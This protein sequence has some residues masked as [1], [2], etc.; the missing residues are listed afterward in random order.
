M[1]P[2]LFA[3]LAVR[4]VISH[5]MVGALSVGLIASIAGHFILETGRREI[6]NIYEDTAF[7]IGHDRE[8]SLI[9]YALGAGTDKEQIRMAMQHSLTGRVGVGYSIFL[10]NGTVLVTNE[11]GDESAPMMPEVR[12]ALSGMDGESIRNNPAGK[13]TFFIAV[14]IKHQDQLY[15]AL[16]FAVVYDDYLDATYQT[17]YLLCLISFLLLIAIGVGS[18]WFSRTISQPIHDLTVVAIRMSNGELQARALPKGPQ[19][20]QQFAATFNRMAG[21]LQANMEGLRAFVANASHE[22]R[23]PL[24]AIRLH[25]DALAEGAVADPEVAMRFLGQLQDEIERMNRTVNDLLDLS[26]IEANRGRIEMEEIDLRDILQETRDFWRVRSQQAA[27]EL[28]LSLPSINPTILGNEDQ[29]RRVI[30][31]LVDNAIKHTPANGWVEISL[32][33][34]VQRGMMR[35]EVRDSGVG[36]P[37]EHLARIFERFYRAEVPHDLKTTG[38]GLGLAIA[39]SIVEAHNGRIGVSSLVGVGSTFWVELQIRQ[40]PSFD[41]K[42]I[43]IRG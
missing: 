37:A 7:R 42:T 12:I 17:L 11:S 13:E 19:E 4:L 29:V 10:A 32:F 22:L 43:P 31:N 23:T 27:I 28:R 26:R 18:W 36:I 16:R 21:Y 14:P 8:V 1:K 9:S 38:S 2:R 20:L 15:G 24:T 35:I 41:R 34:L 3:S 5:L 30:N 39:K 6:E 33:S 25:V 40:V